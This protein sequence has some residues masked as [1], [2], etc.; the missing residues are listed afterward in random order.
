MSTDTPERKPNIAVAEELVDAL[1]PRRSRSDRIPLWPITLIAILALWYVVGESDSRRIRQVIPP[2]FD[3]VDRLWL[4]ISSGLLLHHA[5]TTMTEIVLGFLLA[6]TAAVTVGAAMSLWRSV[7]KLLY[8]CVVSLQSIPKIALAPLLL[9]AFGFGIASKVA[10]ATLIAFFPI[11]IGVLRGLASTPADEVMLLRSLSASRWQVL[12]MVQV[13]RAAPAFMQGLEVGAVLAITGAIVGEF[14]GALEGLG[15]LI[16]FRAS[17]LDTAGMYS[18]LIV[19]SMLGLTLTGFVKWLSSRVIF[20]K[21][22]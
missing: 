17:R 11:L 10:T 12:F 18:A 8:P 13:P 3:T 4:D 5:K 15:Y 9:T 2:L 1:P 14:I 16:V 21:G 19:L 7:D 22:H 20:W 6:A